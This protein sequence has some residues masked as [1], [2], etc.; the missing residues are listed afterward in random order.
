M[1]ILLVIIVTVFV[2]LLAVHFITPAPPAAEPATAPQSSD[3]GLDEAAA[4]K[5][6]Q[7]RKELRE[8]QEF[9]RKEKK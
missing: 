5:E 7:H 1:K 3:L 9:M 4:I 6:M 2:T 8:A